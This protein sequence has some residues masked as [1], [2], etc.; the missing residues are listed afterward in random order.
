MPHVYPLFA[1][2]VYGTDASSGR[3]AKAP[4]VQALEQFAAFAA[5]RWALSQADAMADAEV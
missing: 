1:S 5:A 4:P 3:H 2:L